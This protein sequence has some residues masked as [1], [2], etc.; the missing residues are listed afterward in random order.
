MKDI[1]RP[2]TAKEKRFCSFYVSSGTT[3][4]AAAA[5]GYSNPDKAGAS[6]ILRDDINAQIRSL[7]QIYTKNAREKARAGYERLAFGNVS[8]AVRLMFEE[9]PAD[10]DL[11][12]Y[13]LFN[14]AEI[15][16][17]KDGAME[18]KFFD[19]IKALEKLESL[20]ENVQDNVSRFYSALVGSIKN[21]SEDCTQ[22]EEES[23]E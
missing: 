11:N 18:I 8:D 10:K 12:G 16:R 6:L 22:E 20:E 5:A 1:N 9:N 14:V 7:Y 19:R 15:K 13:D 4:E 2:L 3:R 17:P 21:N 23:F